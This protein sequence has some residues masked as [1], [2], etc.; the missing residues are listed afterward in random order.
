VNKQMWQTDVAIVD[1]KELCEKPERGKLRERER[2]HY[3]VW[4][5]Q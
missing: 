4:E 1:N 2:I 3:N 5:L